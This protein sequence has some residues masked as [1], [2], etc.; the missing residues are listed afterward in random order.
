MMLDQTTNLL[1][2]VAYVLT[3]IPCVIFVINE[4]L[5]VKATA[6]RKSGA[7]YDKELDR[8]KM[9]IDTQFHERLK[10]EAA[11]RNRQI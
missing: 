3:G 6:T 9:V 7:G 5:I 2:N 4:L 1:T 8:L 11:E 10:R